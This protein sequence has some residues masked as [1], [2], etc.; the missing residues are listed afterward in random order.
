M[1]IRLA[2]AALAAMALVGV[3]AT[4]SAAARTEPYAA[5]GPVPALSPATLNARAAAVREQIAAALRTAQRL[6]DPDRR[7]S[8]SAML[9]PGRTFLSFDARSS[10]EAVEVLGDLARAERI[11]VVVP[12]ADGNLENYDSWK[13]A[14]GAARALADDM[15]RIDPR[16]RFAVVAWLGYDTPA[17][18]SPD[19]LTDGRATEA[20]ADLRG[21][22]NDLKRINA[23]ASIGM[24]CHS[25]GTVV[26]AKAAHDLPLSELALY[27]SPGTTYSSAKDLHTQATVW[28]GRKSDDWI[29]EV[30]HV[31]LF[32]LI[33]LGT[34]P[35]SQAFGAQIFHAGAGMHSQYFKPGSASLDALALIA[36]GRDTEVP[37]G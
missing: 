27:G 13:F 11:A 14:G 35:T 30:P 2:R 5:P 34:D 17:M 36:L 18:L 22:V 21:F 9:T 10:G 12:G 20:A 32:G 1:R 25:Y 4:T 8:L 28:A 7:R 19:I 16:T 37:R 29:A 26:C 23:A 33:G 31:R 3:A 15:H 24:L 6:K